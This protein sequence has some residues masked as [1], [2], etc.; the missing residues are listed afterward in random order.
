M[1]TDRNAAL[2][3]ALMAVRELTDAVEARWLREE[4]HAR[5]DDHYRAKLH[6]VAG[7]HSEYR[8]G[9]T[10]DRAF[11]L[12]AALDQ[13]NLATLAIVVD[14]MYELLQPQTTDKGGEVQLKTVKRSYQKVDYVD[15]MPMPVFDANGVPVMQD[16][17]YTYAY[18]R[19][20]AGRGDADRKR[21]KLLSIYADRGMGQRGSG[22]IVAAA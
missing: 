8:R 6:G 2:D 18:I 4:V 3:Q 9:A 10:L 22:G 7:G 14:L 13:D 16:Y 12:A 17:R 21:Q 20:Y 1:K 5:L 15:G 11:E 19:L